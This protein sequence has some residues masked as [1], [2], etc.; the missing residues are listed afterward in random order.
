MS[1]FSAFL[2]VIALSFSPLAAEAGNPAV[3]KPVKTFVNA[4]RYG[5]NDLAMKQV[6]GET[7]GRLLLGEAWDKGSPAER[8]EFVSLFHKVFGSIAFPKLR[9]NLQ[10]IETILYENPKAEGAHQLLTSTLVVLH[11]LKKEEIKVHYLLS[12]SKAGYRLVDVTFEGDRSLLTNVR[13]EQI[14]PL[15]ADGGWPNLLAQLRSRVA[16]LDARN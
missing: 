6:D 16:E 4:I 7:Q 9:D 5:K 3:E 13:E 8:A 1:R 14:T 12:N 2:A 15:L 11:P 10:K